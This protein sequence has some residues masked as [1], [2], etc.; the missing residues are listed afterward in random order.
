MARRGGRTR[1]GDRLC[2]RY[3]ARQSIKF[4]LDNDLSASGDMQSRLAS[5]HVVIH[6]KRTSAPIQAAFPH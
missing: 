6:P 1:G 2:V 5:T 4:S 3:M